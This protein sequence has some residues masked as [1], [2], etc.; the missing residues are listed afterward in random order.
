MTRIVVERIQLPLSTTP[1]EKPPSTLLDGEL[2]VNVADHLIYSGVTGGTAV[3]LDGVPLEPLLAQLQPPLNNGWH[4]TASPAGAGGVPVL[5]GSGQIDPSMVAGTDI[6]PARRGEVPKF[7]Q[8]GLI[9]TSLIDYDFRWVAE[10]STG[11]TAVTDD[12]AGKLVRLDHEGR[13]D[14]RL[15]GLNSLD[16]QGGVYI[17]PAGKAIPAALINSTGFG[18]QTW[19]AAT[20]GGLEYDVN[21]TTG[22]VADVA[23]ANAPD[24]W[25]RIQ[26]GDLL[27]KDTALVMHTID[28]DLMPFD[29][30][31]PRDGSRPM[32]GN[33]NFQD[34]GAGSALDINGVRIVSAK[35]I[36]ASLVEASD[37]A[38]APGIPTGAIRWYVIDGAENSIIVRSGGDPTVGGVDGVAGELYVELGVAAKLYR[39][40]GTGWQMLFDGSV[41][42]EVV[43]LRDQV[44]QLATDLQELKDDLARLKRV[45]R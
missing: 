30:M 42:A 26:T 9:D 5:N 13:I 11:T 43:Q 39:H 37:E 7:K 28:A 23:G 17:G 1:G 36:K 8:N 27:L 20:A 45:G 14:A 19:I 15:L 31:L 3:P 25:Y 18:G 32:Q 38:G 21:F 35:T 6:A 4:T 24:G 12:D 10:P 33:L 44:T 16:Y 22:A 34:Y 2:W 40:D 41:Q 29:H